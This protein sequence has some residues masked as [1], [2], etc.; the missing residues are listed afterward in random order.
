MCVPAACLKY[1]QLSNPLRSGFKF[2]CADVTVTCVHPAWIRSWVVRNGIGLTAAAKGTVSATVAATTTAA[3]TTV[4]RDK[5][6]KLTEM[7]VC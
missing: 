4:L 6:T 5:L 3:V 2:T 7:F 1:E